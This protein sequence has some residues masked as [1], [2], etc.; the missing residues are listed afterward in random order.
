MRGTVTRMTFQIPQ[1]VASESRG[2][3]P[4]IRGIAAERRIRQVDLA[5]ALHISRNSMV[6]RM[7]GKTPFTDIELSILSEVLE[8]PV[9]A[10]FGEVPV[11]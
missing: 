10:F 8:V 11:P 3:A 1:S 5:A 4:K 9:G 6:R 7:V 2:V